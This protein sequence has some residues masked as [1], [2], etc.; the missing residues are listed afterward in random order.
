MKK[1]FAI[2][3]ACVVFWFGASTSAAL[4]ADHVKVVVNNKQLSFDV[5]PKIENGRVLVPIRFIAEELGANIEKW[6]P[7]TGS[8]HISLDNVEVELTLGSKIGY[9]NEETLDLDAPPRT[10]NGRTM[11]PLRFVSEALG[12]G[13][14]FYG[15]S[16]TIFIISQDYISE[17]TEKLNTITSSAPHDKVHELV[18]GEFRNWVPLLSM[19]NAIANP[20]NTYSLY[21]IWFPEKETK[22]F[23]IRIIN[24]M[25]SGD[26]MMYSQPWLDSSP[27]PIDDLIVFID[28]S[29]KE[30][31]ILWVG[32]LTNRK[33]KISIPFSNEQIDRQL[34][35][36]LDDEWGYIKTVGEKPKF[37]K[38]LS[39]YTFLPWSGFIP[40]ERFYPEFRE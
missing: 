30:V 17:L 22:Q 19:H 2:G 21:N 28:I 8:I 35:A 11:V 32:S 31:S 20:I 15:D 27:A 6:D 23:A 16:N 33:D 24:R 36:I 37:D 4:A 12:A 3:I 38:N 5:P 9:V 25:R 13:V 10:T 1:W 39:G 34:K 29:P 14:K 18:G 26:R 40:L 7:T